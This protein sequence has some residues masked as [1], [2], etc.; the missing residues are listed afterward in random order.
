MSLTRQ[1]NRLEAM[2]NAHLSTS[3][4]LILFF[5]S[6]SSS[7]SL[8]PPPPRPIKRKRTTAAAPSLPPPIHTNNPLLPQPN[9]LALLLSVDGRRQV[10]DLNL[11][12]DH[13]CMPG[14]RWSMD[15]DGKHGLGLK[16]ILS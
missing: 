2:S 12:L 6:F 14:A 15:S 7:S 3:P 1:V 16:R 8:S 13:A 11:L 9:L 4:L 10:N 5:L